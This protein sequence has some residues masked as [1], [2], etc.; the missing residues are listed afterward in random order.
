MSEINTDSK[1]SG[2]KGKP[3]KMSTHVDF[4]PMVDLGFLLIT[5][6]LLATTMIKPQT[7]ELAMPSKEKDPNNKDAGAVKASRAVTIILDKDNKVYY[8]EGMQETGKPRPIV[9]ATNFS[10]KTGI[11]KFLI[12][13]NFT[14]MKKVKELDMEDLKKPMPDSIYERKKSEILQEKETKSKTSPVV[15]IK[16]TE[17]ATYKN[18]IDILDEMAICNIGSYAIVDVT[19]EDK[20]WIKESKK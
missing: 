11:R 19:P 9:V 3:K 18:L 16:A 7:M 1:N 17:G 4:T 2:K 8:W 10:G 12:E 5:F 6:F 13:R 15:V 14:I 20:L